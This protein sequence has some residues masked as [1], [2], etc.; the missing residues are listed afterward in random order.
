[1]VGGGVRVGVMVAVEVG[2]EVLV[3]GT[4]VGVSVGVRVNVGDGEGVT[5]VV[6]STTIV[7]LKAAGSGGSG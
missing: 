6:G 2:V 1:M 5:V 3:G 7:R 4:R